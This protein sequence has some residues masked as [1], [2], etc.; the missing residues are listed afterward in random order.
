MDLSNPIRTARDLPISPVIDS[1]VLIDMFDQESLRHEVAKDLGDWL[2]DNRVKAFM[3]WTGM[4]ELNRV[5]TRI[6]IEN[7]N[8]Q[9]ATHFTQERPVVFERIPVDAAFFKKY[10]CRELP[11]TKAADM[12]FLSIAYVDKNGQIQFT[13]KFKSFKTG[14]KKVY[15]LRLS[16]SSFIDV[17]DEHLIFTDK[18][19]VEFKKIR[20]KKENYKI[21]GIKKDF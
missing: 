1:C 17:T 11:Y 12:L 13:D 8:H 19:C 6:R 15:R 20:E 16:N 18:G 2:I 5:I 10:F 9:L 4:F 7:P 21:Y 14:N 3:P